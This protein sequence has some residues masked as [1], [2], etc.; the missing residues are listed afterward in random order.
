M[1]RSFFM[2]G[3]WWLVN[4]F[5][6]TPTVH[7]NPRKGVFG[8]VPDNARIQL[9]NAVMPNDTQPGSLFTLDKRIPAWGIVL[10]VGGMVAQGVNTF[11]SN[12]ALTAAVKEQKEATAAQLTAVAQDIRSIN[13]EVYR[14]NVAGVEVRAELRDSLRRL[15]AL[16]QQVQQIQQRR[17]AGGP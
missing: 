1:S 8:R 7:E 17:P 16:E 6:A 11:Y 4:T 14:S 15:Q 2:M 9:E 5:C 10:V 12:Q 13:T 3:P